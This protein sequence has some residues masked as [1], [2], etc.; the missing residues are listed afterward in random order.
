MKVA[1]ELEPDRPLSSFD[2]TV[3]EETPAETRIG[4]SKSR[5]LKI[6]PQ[7]DTYPRL[8]SF[9]QTPLGI[10]ALLG[11]FAGGLLI[12][13]VNSWIEMTAAVALMAIYPVRRRLL[14]SLTAMYWLFFHSTW[15]N[16]TFLRA[17][18]KTEGQKT[19]WTLT[20]LVSGILT[21]VFCALA[22]YFRYVQLARGRHVSLLAKRPVLCLMASYA[23]VLATAGMLPLG[24]M[25]RL[26]V[27][28][29]ISV[30][31]PY[32]WYFAYALKDASAKT[33]NGAILQFGTLRPFWGGTGVPYAKGAAN[34]R[35]IE[36]RN[37]EDLSIIQLKAIKLLIWAFIVRIPL[38]T[39]QVFV[40]GK[41]PRDPLFIGLAGWNVPTLGVPEL[42]RALLLAALPVQIAWASLIA[43]FAQAM[44][45]ITVS[46][47]IVIACC[48]MAGYNALRNTYRPLESRTIAEFWNRYYYYFKELLVDF[49]FFPV[50]MRYFKKNRQLRLFV[51]TMAAATLGNLVYHFLRDYR[52]V[53]QMG[54][55]QALLG[56]RVYI[57]YAT[58]LG[59]AIGVSQWRGHGKVP[60]P[61][62]AAWWR[63][64]LASAGVMFFFCLLE[65]FD[66]EG[67]TYSL[68]QCFRFFLHLFFI[69]A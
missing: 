57:F 24:G 22:A 42:S 48:R 4:R 26:L 31:A 5:R 44:L 56:F 17:L 65:V 13:H 69:P 67:R 53:A 40:Y 66:Q 3:L 19:D 29:A 54:L 27:W 14:T 25:M 20:A 63:R 41:M 62:D 58:I 38:L 1:P 36:A 43:H 9:A 23:A 49:F 6:V 55:W 47:S 10:A 51:A 32:L 52:Y 33:P 39:L 34:L 12:N 37:S 64:T 11:A 21:A 16:W 68:T 61:S 30:T 28:G 60:L 18:A 35:K 45:E 50:F 15:L 2:Q 59:L 7:L 8:V 46:G